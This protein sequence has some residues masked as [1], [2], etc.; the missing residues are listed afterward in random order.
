MREVL[1]AVLIG[2]W[3]L[4]LAFLVF[5]VVVNWTL[6][7]VLT[8]IGPK[9]RGEW[10][11]EPGAPPYRRQLLERFDNGELHHNCNS[12]I[13]WIGVLIFITVTIL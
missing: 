11:D 8:M 10:A 2:F 9:R 4:F 3:K 6:F 12:L 1:L 5:V 7:L 13:L